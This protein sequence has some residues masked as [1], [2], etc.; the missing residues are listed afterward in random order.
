MDMPQQSC[1]QNEVFCIFVVI[2][3]SLDN[4]IY[5]RALQLKKYYKELFKITI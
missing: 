1:R 4:K 5:K 2:F 3:L